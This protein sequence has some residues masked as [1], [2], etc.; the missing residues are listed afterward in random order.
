M[1]KKSVQLFIYC[2]LTTFLILFF[3]FT[4]RV[5]SQEKANPV[6]VV[7]SGE[8]KNFFY[9]LVNIPKSIIGFL[10][11]FK[12]IPGIYQE[13]AYPQGSSQ[14]NLA[15]SQPG[16]FPAGGRSLPDCG[17]SYFQETLTEERPF[18][19]WDKLTALI[20]G[21][22]KT[23]QILVGEECRY[24]IARIPTDAVPQTPGEAGDQAWDSCKAGGGSDNDCR[25]AAEASWT[26]FSQDNPNWK[27]DL[28]NRGDFEKLAYEQSIADTARKAMIQQILLQKGYTDTNQFTLEDIKAVQNAGLK[29]SQE[30]IVRETAGRYG[31]DTG[32]ILDSE[33]KYIMDCLRL[34]EM[35]RR[36]LYVDQLANNLTV[37][38]GGIFGLPDGK[39]FI[40]VG[41]DST[42]KPIISPQDNPEVKIT[43]S[44]FGRISKEDYQNIINLSQTIEN[45]LIA[46]QTRRQTQQQTQPSTAPVA[47][48]W[49]FTQASSAPVSNAQRP[50]PAPS[51]AKTGSFA[52]TV[53]PQASSQPSG[54]TWDFTALEKSRQKQKELSIPT[55]EQTQQQTAEKT[56]PQQEQNWIQAVNEGQQSVLTRTGLQTT[57]QTGAGVSSQGQSTTG[58]SQISGQAGGGSG[59]SSETGNS[60]II[61]SLSRF[62]QKSISAIQ[63]QYI[64]GST[65]Y[66]QTP[67]NY[68]SGGFPLNT[69][70]S[71][72]QTT[73]NGYGGKPTVNEGYGS[74]PINKNLFTSAIQSFISRLPFLGISSPSQ[75]P[76][77]PVTNQ[78]Y[79]PGQQQQ[80][81]SGNQTLIDIANRQ[82]SQ[83]P[84][85][86]NQWQTTI[87]LDKPFAGEEIKPQ[88]GGNWDFIQDIYNQYTQERDKVLAENG[89][90]MGDEVSVGK[91]KYIVAGYNYN[92]KEITFQK[93]NSEQKVLVLPETLKGKNAQEVISQRTS[94][95]WGKLLENV[96][97]RYLTSKTESNWIANIP[98]EK[99]RIEIN[100]VPTDVYLG[101]IDPRIIESI[102]NTEIPGCN[103]YCK[104][105]IYAELMMETHSQFDDDLIT[106]KILPDGTKRYYFTEKALN[107][108]SQDRLSSNIFQFVLGQANFDD[109]GNLV[110]DKSVNFKICNKANGGRDCEY[111][112]VQQGDKQV[113]T[114][115]R[116]DQAVKLAAMINNMAV[117][118]YRADKLYQELLNKGYSPEQLKI[119]DLPFDS[120]IQYRSA[121]NEDVQNAINNVLNTLYLS[122]EV[123]KEIE[124][125]ST[126]TNPITQEDFYGMAKGYHGSLRGYSRFGGSNY[127][128]VMNE[129]Y[130][131]LTTETNQQP[132]NLFYLIKESIN[133]IFNI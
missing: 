22:P 16:F 50:A 1:D 41:T 93:Q 99:I 114:L 91:D 25:S 97:S 14:P 38:I 121:S 47:N 70:E 75:V 77:Q 124:K 71:P 11:N 59:V 48:P 102:N 83:A 94:G 129:I 15:S 126:L 104:I 66:R 101:R 111:T 7:L 87:S 120:Y 55:S 98:E 49:A 90:K 33:F 65:T 23:P 21:Q 3:F 125:I 20:F 42:G 19:W 13:E 9:R 10:F 79:G 76:S 68:R 56:Q 12:Q 86:L 44:N 131:K 5:Y 58:Q 39:K 103:S 92:T 127:G 123:K 31:I 108:G 2:F 26:K 116:L 8:D 106:E 128:D 6:R 67:N 4:S 46:E 61:T 34:E 62:V 43:L 17:E 107:I 81:M 88:E 36:L 51:S 24:D 37:A 110:L 105:G 45:N 35:E 40:V 85:G 100:G 95:G 130:K 73:T 112:L 119:G 132:E 32:K 118:K 60:S 115:T 89:L 18:N 57:S 64:P 109:T 122:E 117:V 69:Q 30:Q 53:E 78:G 113:I 63:E 29:A 54:G 74:G 82:V 52:F 96:F 84:T 80:P 133:S 72:A 27:T 28:I